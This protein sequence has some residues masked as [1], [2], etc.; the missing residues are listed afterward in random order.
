MDSPPQ[1]SRSGCDRPK[2]FID[3]ELD[4][5]LVSHLEQERLA[6]FLVR[7]VGALHDFEDLHRPLT[8]RG[9]NFFSILQHL[10]FPFLY[11][12]ILHMYSLDDLYNRRER[13]FVG[14]SAWHRLMIA[15]GIT[16]SAACLGMG[17]T[18]MAVI[19]AGGRLVA[20][21]ICWISPVIASR[22][23]WSMMTTN[24][25]RYLAVLK[26]SSVHFLH[27][28]HREIRRERILRHR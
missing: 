21:V 15:L 6:G 5:A 11:C 18:A 9:H 10:S 25:C 19:D 26:S 22:A 7:H 14:C 1:A 24:I 4:S 2:T 3:V 28:A 23:R 13:S 27:M 17:F 12:L 20:F 16:G 8:K